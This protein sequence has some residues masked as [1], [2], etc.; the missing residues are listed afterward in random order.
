MALTLPRRVDVF[1]VAVYYG[2]QQVSLRVF[3]TERERNA[4]V[5]S[6]DGSPFQFRTEQSSLLLSPPVRE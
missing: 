5:A 4:F 1:A 3:G 2:T 6:L